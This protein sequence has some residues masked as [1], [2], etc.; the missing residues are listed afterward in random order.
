MLPKAQDQHQVRMGKAC[1][2]AGLLDKRVQASGK[3]SAVLFTPQY[4][5]H[6]FAAQAQRAG[7]ILPDD[8]RTLK[9]AVKG[10][11]ENMGVAGLNNVLDL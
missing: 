8:D 7:H 2:L 10:V 11:I 6:L 3:G 5:T 4:Q 1:Q 9:F